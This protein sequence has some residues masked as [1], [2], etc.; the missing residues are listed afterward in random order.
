MFFD[1]ITQIIVATTELIEAE[2]KQLRQRV[3]GL[4]VACLLLLTAVF[5]SLFGIYM[6]FKPFFSWLERCCGTDF[7]YL[8]CATIAFVFAGG[9]AWSSKKMI[10]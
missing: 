9:L 1:R 10:K 5:V 3:Y 7:A 4:W 8:I 6:A 2:G